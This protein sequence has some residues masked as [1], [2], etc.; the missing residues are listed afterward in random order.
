MALEK[1]DIQKKK[2]ELEEQFKAKQK[3]IGIHKRAIAEASVEMSRLK[4]AYRVLTELEETFGKKVE[5]IK[6]TKAP[7][8]N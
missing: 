2:K 3:E 1:K 7:G 4:G 5:P 6:S 8:K